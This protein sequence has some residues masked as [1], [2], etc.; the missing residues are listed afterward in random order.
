MA[1]TVVVKLTDDLDGT[2]ASETVTF[3]LGGAEYEIDLSDK[4]KAAL[5]KALE[6]YVAVG[7]KVGGR[8]TRRST[9]SGRDDLDQIRVW[10]RANGRK[11]S[12][13]GRVASSVI[14]AYDEAQK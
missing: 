6:K 9:A 4:N 2:E 3:A 13:R 12:D 10:A 14:A 1:K 7:R 8:R 5:D 11:V